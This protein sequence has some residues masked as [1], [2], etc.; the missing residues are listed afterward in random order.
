MDVGIYEAKSKLSQLV[1]KAEAG[2]EV[3]LTRRGR[4]VA[5]IVNVAPAARRN[6]ALLLREI[7]ALARRVKIPKRVSIRDIVAEGRD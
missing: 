2:E 3:I 4:P 1:E 7:R 5:K 6:R